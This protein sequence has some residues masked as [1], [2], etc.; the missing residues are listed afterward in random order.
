MNQGMISPAR[1][2]RAAAPLLAIGGMCGLAWAAGLRGLMAELAG[3]GSDVGWYGT[4][5]QILLPGVIVGILLGWAE[6]VR[7]TG[8]RR[9]WRWLAAA[10]VVFTVAVFVSPEVV[11]AVLHGQPLLGGGVG[12]S[13]IAIP[14]LGMAGGY[15]MSGRGPRWARILLGVVAIVPVP[16]WAFASPLFGSA[17]ALS[18]PR[19]AWTA[20]F[21][22]SFIGTLD[23]ACTI[24]HRPV[25]QAGPAMPER[26]GP[27]KLSSIPDGF[28]RVRGGELPRRSGSAPR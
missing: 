16:G 5:A 18:T 6:H 11:K 9:G 13:A 23:L 1:T 8:G 2:R 12:G 15:A 3:S 21:F 20:L 25:V 14:L 24:P 19:G 22:Y 26:C 7:R 4:F 28:A 10:P 27:A 17:F